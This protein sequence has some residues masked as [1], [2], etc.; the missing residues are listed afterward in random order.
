MGN[1]DLNKEIVNSAGRLNIIG[2]LTDYDQGLT[3]Y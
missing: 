2:E 3:K 1:Q